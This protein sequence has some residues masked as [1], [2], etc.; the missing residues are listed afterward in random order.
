MTKKR[1]KQIIEKYNPADEV[2]RCP[3]GRAHVKK[4]LDTYA[5][6][7]VNLYGIISKEDLAGIFNSQNTEQTNAEEVFT[8][9]LPV[10]IKNYRASDDEHERCSYYFYKDCIIHCWAVDNFD[11]ADFLLREQEGKPRFIPKKQEFLNYENVYYEEETQKMNWINT[12]KFILDEWSDNDGVFE[13][14][15]E[16]KDCSKLFGRSDIH[17]QLR[18]YGLSFTS[19][20][21]IQP[22]FDLLNNAHNNTRM[23]INKG[24][25]PNE[26]IQITRKQ[27]QENGQDEVTLH[28]HRE[29]GANEPCPCGSGKKYKDCC[30]L[31]A[32]ISG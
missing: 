1:A 13:F 3:N 20:K 17:N 11:F 16:V 7:A 23:W 25:T 28:E 14:Y 30:G 32:V 18:E 12:L 5:R 6:A 15:N 26:L 4:L 9:L 2:I 19:E 21:H 29:I 8:L 24:H 27:R 31:V 10:V 22:F